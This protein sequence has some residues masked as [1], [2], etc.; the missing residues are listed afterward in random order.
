MDNNISSPSRLTIDINGSVITVT[1]AAQNVLW[2]GAAV[3][4]AEETAGS[5]ASREPSAPAAG[6]VLAAAKLP[7]FTP[8]LYAAKGEQRRYRTGRNQQI[9]IKATVAT[10]EKFYRLA[11]ASGDPLGEILDQALTALEE[12]RK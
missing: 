2:P 6:Q 4:L 11:D 5:K 8:D 3:G 7:V 10:I 1:N 9:N 12:S